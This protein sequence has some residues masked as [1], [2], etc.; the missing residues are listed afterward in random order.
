V[1]SRY[2]KPVYRAHATL[3]IENPAEGTVNLRGADLQ[4]DGALSSPESYLPTQILILQSR[5]FGSE[6][7][8]NSGDHQLPVAVKIRVETELPN[9]ADLV[10][11][12]QSTIFSRIRERNRQ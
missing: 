9:R 2:S 1:L 7:A 10:R 4:A 12:L 11:F 6:Q 5:R 8:Q 3:E